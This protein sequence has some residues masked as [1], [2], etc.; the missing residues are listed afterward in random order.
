MW[1][2]EEEVKRGD[3]AGAFNSLY[4]SWSTM[5]SFDRSRAAKMEGGEIK[6]GEERGKKEEKAQGENKDL[7]QQG[8]TCPCFWI[9]G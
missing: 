1:Q 7:V 5:S 4:G 6:S 8:H 2:K 9:V 3:N